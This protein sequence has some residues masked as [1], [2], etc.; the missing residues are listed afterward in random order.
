MKSRQEIE[1]I[2]LVFAIIQNSF[3]GYE[4]ANPGQKVVNAFPVSIIDS[5]IL[6]Y[7]FRFGNSY[8]LLCAFVIID[9]YYNI[10]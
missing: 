8:I 9:V 5:E 7:M 3:N 6:E 4:K 2:F 10:S 1:T